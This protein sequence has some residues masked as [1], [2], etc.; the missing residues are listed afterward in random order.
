MTIPRTRS[1]RRQFNALPAD[2]EPVSTKAPREL[3]RAFE[4]YCTRLGRPK[5]EQLRR[6][7]LSRV[8]EQRRLE[9]VRAGQLAGGAHG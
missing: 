1:G 2:S 7:M 3:S 6:L 4:D 5:A 8:R 9:R